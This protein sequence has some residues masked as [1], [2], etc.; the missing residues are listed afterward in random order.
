MA[1]I[2]IVDDEEKI[3]KLLRAELKDAGHAAHS[4]TQPEEAVELIRKRPPDI[5]ITD[6]RM[7]G[8]DG[9]ALLKKTKEMSASTDVIVMTAYAAVETALETMKE[10]AYDYIVKPFKT[11]ELLLLIHRLEEKRRLEAENQ[12][13]RSYLSGGPAQEI[14]GQSAAIANIRKVIGDLKN[15]DVAVL[16]R[17]ESG[18]GKELVARAIHKNSKRANGPFLALNCA[19]IP[20]GLLES[21]LFGYEK[22]AFTGATR[23]KPGH[24][25]LANGG[26][27][28]LDEIGDLSLPLQAKLLRVLE[29]GQIRPLGSEKEINVDFR[30]I[31]ATHRSLEDAIASRDFREDLF[32][33]I[34]VFPIHIPPLRERKEDI[35]ELSLHFLSQA[36]RSGGDL[37]DAAAEKLEGYPWLG[38]IRELRNVLERAM[39]VRPTGRILADDIHLGTVVS[40]SLSGTNAAEERPDA[41]NLEEME[42]QLIRKAIE[43]AR[44]NKS[45]AARLLGITRRALYGRLERYGIE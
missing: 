13:L 7:P 12:G 33:R 25:Q 10:G 21:E 31:T 18:T 26:T 19:A 38:N 36:G 23:K 39:I 34:N 8:M 6:L 37:S 2:L 32:Y 43:R 35:R 14:I 1:E 44:G 45:E 5:L 41:F 42:K 27:L 20:E 28:F 30:F 15:S 11:D 9:I 3:C 4:T 22:G 40:T 24:F 16:I 17:G 29:Y